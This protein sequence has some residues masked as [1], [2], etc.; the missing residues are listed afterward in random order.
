MAENKGNIKTHQT[1]IQ[2]VYAREIWQHEHSLPIKINFRK[3]K[4]S[5][6]VSHNCWF[7]EMPQR[8]WNLK[9]IILYW[10]H[11]IAKSGSTS[12]IV[13]SKSTN[14]SGPDPNFVD[15]RTY[16]IFFLFQNQ[17]LCKTRSED[18]RIYIWYTGFKFR[19]ITNM[20]FLKSSNL[21]KIS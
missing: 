10:C 1:H 17:Q 15:W 3:I 12:S 16:Q 21:Y 13:Y 4:S 19:R 7:W 20:K 14:K 18:T 9:D 8:V 2:F 6:R 5:E 11:R